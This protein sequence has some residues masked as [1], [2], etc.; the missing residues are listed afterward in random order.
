M[1]PFNYQAYM[2]SPYAQPGQAPYQ[3]YAPPGFQ[4]GQYNQYA[5]NVSGFNYPNYA[6]HVSATNFEEFDNYKGQ[7]EMYDQ[8]GSGAQ[9]PQGAGSEGYQTA[10]NASKSTSA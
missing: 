10:W 1:A 6:S 9:Q 4:R 2:P 3:Q 7:H 5:P 8:N